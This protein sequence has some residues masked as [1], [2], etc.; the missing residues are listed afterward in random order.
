M[1]FIF[2][3]AISCYVL[4]VLPGTRG[5]RNGLSPGERCMPAIIEQALLTAAKKRKLIPLIGAGVSRAAQIGNN[6]GEH[7]FPAWRELAE[8]M[9]AEAKTKKLIDEAE[10]NKLEKSLDEEFTYV[11]ESLYFNLP[12]LTYQEILLREFSP[13][14]A[15]PAKIHQD[16]LRLDAPIILTINYDTL[17]ED[18]YAQQAT[19]AADV[20]TY[21]QTDFVSTMIEERLARRKTPPDDAPLAAADD[22]PLIFKTFG[23]IRQPFDMI[24]TPRRFRK[25]VQQERNLPELL[26]SL[27]IRNTVILFGF[28]AVDVELE[29]LLKKLSEYLDYT[30]GPDYIFLK[31]VNIDEEKTRSFES[32]YKITPIYFESDA[33]IFDLVGRLADETQK[34]AGD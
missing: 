6:K 5:A 27:F 33:E 17:L 22:R 8:K 19:Q 28:S 31:D 7:F 11:A 23:T 30:A 21:R 13:R 14:G 2:T 1:L 24:L 34:R 25:T 4:L 10:L 29:V 18:A 12:T 3:K 9:I 15:K 26:S 32:R 20:Y 16:I